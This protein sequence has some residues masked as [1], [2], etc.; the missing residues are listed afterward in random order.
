M[1]GQAKLQSPENVNRCGCGREGVH[2]SVYVHVYKDEVSTHLYAC[3]RTE[4]YVCVHPCMKG[5]CECACV[6]VCVSVYSHVRG[7]L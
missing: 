4:M 2:M 1:I 3:L 7:Y 6:S 5:G